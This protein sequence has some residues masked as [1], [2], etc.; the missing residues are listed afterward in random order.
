MTTPPRGT[1]QPS[2]LEGEGGEA[3]ASPGEGEQPLRDA[4]SWRLSVDA[5]TTQRDRPERKANA[6]KLRSA[7]TEAEQAL[8]RLLRSRRLEGHKFR[9]QHPVGR[10]I[11]DYICL[12]AK[13]IV[14]ADGGQHESNFAD[15][16]RTA[17]LENRGFRVLRFWNNEILENSDG[18]LVALLGALTARC[19]DV[20]ERD[21]QA[22]S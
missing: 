7:M 8:W 18:V 19:V 14:E 6:R 1:E 9:R 13:L 11:A 15:A 17:W 5:I 22:S 10:Y 2:P 16:A 20:A 12:E 3:Q 4:R 21:R